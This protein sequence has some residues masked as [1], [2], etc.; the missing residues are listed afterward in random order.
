METCADKD[1]LFQQ[2]RRQEELIGTGQAPTG[3]TARWALLEPDGVREE[4]GEREG[5]R[6][7]GEAFLCV[8]RTAFFFE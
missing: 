5:T 2:S 3:A 4:G 6:I 8:G 1:P 7:T